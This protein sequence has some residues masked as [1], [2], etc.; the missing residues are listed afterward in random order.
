[1]RA[2]ARRAGA[3]FL[4]A[5]ISQ[6]WSSPYGSYSRLVSELRSAGHDVIDVVAEPGWDA[7]AMLIPGDGHWNTRGN[8][9]VAGL[10]ADRL[11]DGR[12]PRRLPVSGTP[13]GRS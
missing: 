8:A 12:D 3:S 2:E 5:A 11:R 7:K 10:L 13:S 4:V 6:F 9:F 1:M